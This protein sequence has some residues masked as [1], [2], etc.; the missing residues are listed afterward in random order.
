MARRHHGRG[1]IC[2]DVFTDHK[3]GVIRILPYSFHLVVDLFVGVVFVIAPFA[4]GF[5]GLDACYYWANGAAV[6]L[7]V[8]LHKPE[9][10]QVRMASA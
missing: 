7:V 4:L 6:L 9:A 2:P 1:G 5:A 10:V 8:S 3:T